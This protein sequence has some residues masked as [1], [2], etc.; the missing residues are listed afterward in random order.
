MENPH[1]PKNK[2]ILPEKM[3]Y[4]WIIE[5]QQG[6]ISFKSIG[7][8]LFIRKLPEILETQSL[9]LATR[10]GISFSNELVLC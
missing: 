5:L 2:E 6:K 10:G 8:E 3:E 1:L 4:D 9:S 7:F